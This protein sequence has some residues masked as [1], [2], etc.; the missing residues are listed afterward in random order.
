MTPDQER[1]ELALLYLIQLEKD[2][3]RLH[4]AGPGGEEPNENY[5]EVLGILKR[6]KEILRNED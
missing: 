5:D 6:V 4:L 1:I 2:V 3:Q